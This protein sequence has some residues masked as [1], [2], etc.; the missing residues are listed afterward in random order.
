MIHGGYVQT[1]EACSNYEDII[2][3]MQEGRKFLAD[4][5]NV[6]PTIGWQLDPFGH[7]VA[8]ARLFAEMGLDS[9]VFARVSD[10]TKT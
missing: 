4:E 1:D 9:M 7:S 3:N 5:F 8:N 10:D 6:N 2:T